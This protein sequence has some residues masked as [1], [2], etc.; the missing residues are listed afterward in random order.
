MANGT[1]KGGA[2]QKAQEEKAV[3]NSGAK[4]LKQLVTQMMPQIAKALPSVMTPE[5]FGRMMQTLLSTNPDLMNCTP[6]SFM[7]AMM[8]AAQLGLEPNTSMGQAYLI[9]FRNKGVLEV[10]F[11][12]GY[13]GWLTLA[14]RS[15]EIL[16]IAS[17][18]VYENDF[19]EYELGLEQKLRHKPAL[20]DRGNVVQYYAIYKT[21]DGGSGFCVMSVEDIKKHANKY[22]KSA[23]SSYSPWNTN[24]DEM[25][26][27]TVLKKLLKYAPM[28]TDFARAVS[29]DETIKTTISED[30]I[31]MPDETAVTVDAEPV[32][33]PQETEKTP[34]NGEQN[35]L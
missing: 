13:R 27:K 23:N 21:K 14:Y 35:L 22:S 4:N 12:V 20:K 2:I 11:Q 9:P 1:V 30:M 31:D 16:T 17:Y 3:Q 5:R 24:F 8:Q 7:S 26:K 15:G 33:A 6:M 10:Q 28:K 34:E 18:E 25:A 29:T 32:E 19:F